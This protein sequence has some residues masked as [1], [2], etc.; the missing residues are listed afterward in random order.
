VKLVEIEIDKLIVDSAELSPVS[1]EQF[2][3]LVEQ[4]LQQRMRI[5]NM[6]TLP[7]AKDSV[8]ISIPSVAHR[9]MSGRVQFAANIAQAIHQ[10]MVQ[11]V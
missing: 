7:A 3:A 11:E 9:D 1:G 4:A 2:R 5:A 8:A 10:G 6:A